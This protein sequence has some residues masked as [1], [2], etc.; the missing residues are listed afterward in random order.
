MT[1]LASGRFGESNA[2]D[3]CPDCGSLW[4]HSERLRTWDEQAIGGWEDWQFCS[5]CKCELFYP[6]IRPFNQS[7]PSA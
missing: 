3:T 6:V 7:A 1:G 5:A 4:S 2:P